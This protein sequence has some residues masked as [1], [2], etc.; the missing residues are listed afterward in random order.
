ME[1]APLKSLGF[2]LGLI[3]GSAI[4]A[5]GIIAPLAVFMA[6]EAE[7]DRTVKNFRNLLFYVFFCGFKGS[8]DQF[9][10][11]IYVLQ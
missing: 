5:L 6:G 4:L 9:C 10:R 11:Q 3:I 1:L 7:T 2:I 8:C